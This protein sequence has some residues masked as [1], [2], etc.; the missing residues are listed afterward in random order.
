MMRKSVSRRLFLYLFWSDPV[1][2]C[3][4]LRVQY[5]SALAPIL[6]SKDWIRWGLSQPVVL[7]IR[8]CYLA[9]AI[10]HRAGVGS[11]TQTFFTCSLPRRAGGDGAGGG[12]NRWRSHGRFCTCAVFSFCGIWKIS[13]LGNPGGC[14][15]TSSRR[16]SE[17]FTFRPIEIPLWC[18]YFCNIE[19]KSVR[20]SPPG[21]KCFR[22]DF[23]DFDRLSVRRKVYLGGEEFCKQIQTGWFKVNGPSIKSEKVTPFWRI[24]S[25]NFAHMFYE[26]L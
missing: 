6:S 24:R 1:Q 14:R 2:R 13:C 3:F 22:G 4:S 15:F 7:P 5:S 17:Q 18:Q 20:K 10:G 12:V 21:I 16:Y 11:L 25:W 8:P 26:P 23:S 19:A 9:L